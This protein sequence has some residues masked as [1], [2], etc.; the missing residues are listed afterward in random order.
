MSFDDLPEH[1]ADLP[2][3][4]TDLASDVLDL[5]VTEADRSSSALVLLLCD[6]E[7][8]LIQ[9]C[10][11][12]EVDR[13]ASELERRSVL[14]VFVQAMRDRPSGLVVGLARPGPATPDDLDR[15]W[16]QSAIDAC[17][18]TSVTLL[19]T[20]LVAMSEVVPLPP[21]TEDAA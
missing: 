8:R 6:E 13:A 18:G 4:D 15:A 2:L 16:H 11:I 1:W 20:H 7:H 10:C 19:S 21:A 5:L 17:R 14:D 9:P 3:S 12:N